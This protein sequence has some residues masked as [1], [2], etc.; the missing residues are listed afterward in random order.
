MITERVQS[1]GVVTA[2]TGRLRR[3]VH[4]AL[5]T[6]MGAGAVGALLCN[7]TLAQ[8]PQ[9]TPE[10]RSTLEEVIVSARYRDETL[11]T[12]PLAITAVT[13]DDLQA[14]N[15]ANVDDLG[16]V[17]P[18]TF[19]VPGAAGALGA[20]TVSMRGVSQLDFNFAF[21]PGVGIYIDDVYRPTLLGSD[22]DLMD[23]DRVEV[24]RGPQGTLF[25]KNSMG[26]ALRI[27]SKVPQGD[28]TGYVEA[29]AGNFDRLDFRGS[30]DTTLVPDKLFLR[31]SGVQ[32]HIDGY[33]RL[34][35]FACQMH[36][37]GTPELI[38]DG[39]G[40]NAYSNA[41]DCTTGRQGGQ[42]LKAGRVML[43]YVVN[44]RAEINFSLDKTND[45]KQV[46]PDVTIGAISQAAASAQGLLN[47]SIYP[48]VLPDGTRNPNAPA[49]VWDS[50]FLAPD[51]YTSYARTNSPNVANMHEWGMA[52]S[53]SYEFTDSVRAK[54]ILGH[55]SYEFRSSFNAD[56]S[57]YGFIQN[58]N[59]IHHTQDSAELQ[60]SGESFG[61]RLE[62]TTGAFYFDGSTHM[63]GHILYAGLSF[64]QDDDFTDKN[65][66]AFLHAVYRMTEAL[67]LS[68]GVR[69]SK[70]EKIFSFHHPG[71]GP[72]IAP[73]SNSFE[74]TRP[75]W[76]VGLK[77]QLTDEL[78]LYTTASTGYRP[79]G[80]NPRP[81]IVPDQLVP[82]EGEEMTSYELGLKATLLEG[83]MQLN[84]AGFYSDYSSHIS[85]ATLK[86][87]VGAPGTPA[88]VVP[89]VTC[90]AGTLFE[91]PWF[92]YFSDEA[93]VRGVEAELAFEPLDGLLFTASGGWNEFESDVTDPTAPNYRHPDNLTQPEFNASAGLQ[94]ALETAV[95][96][97][98]PR[99]DWTYQSEMTYSGVLSLPF[100]P[101]FGLDAAA[102]KELTSTPSRSLFN[103]R[104]GFASG[105]GGWEAALAAT[106]LFDKFYW[107]N[108]FDLSG[109]VVS[110]MPSRSREWSFT[111]RRNFK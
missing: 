57:P 77:Y 84:L 78:M 76:T 61:Q 54:L 102:A 108:K 103:A 18:N 36:A 111:V 58:W 80:V 43:R 71:I 10:V 60:I 79:G 30:F 74:D 51:P 94:Y 22:L 62:W 68:A 32:K 16:R 53:A 19:I 104:I 96:T 44:D 86:Q 89:N 93:T 63:G 92:A 35:D 91:A 65:Q 67:S 37:N 4:T 6:A 70:N 21:E 98:T 49:V 14:R 64:D 81:I 87:C 29:T 13:A 90:P 107:Q 48:W 46:S 33:V 31:V 100:D 56:A 95:G 20:P 69:Y 52:G 24:L 7:V 55:R 5:H 85:Q 110:G 1:G 105:D 59:P 45:D 73:L 83:R 82:F 23:I 40:T 17:V 47:P 9:S 66:S 97:I 38:P 27:V 72:P 26:G 15:I 109:M 2:N 3:T 11:Q 39:V 106:N 42:D 75:D 101:R 8:T 28:D 88:P 34:V 25:G 12:T 99:L 50:R 41:S